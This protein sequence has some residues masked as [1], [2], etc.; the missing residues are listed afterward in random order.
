MET[1]REESNKLHQNTLD[2]LDEIV[3]EVH[4]I[5]E[6]Y[7]EKSS[8]CMFNDLKIPLQ[9]LQ[10]RANREFQII[11]ENDLIRV[12]DRLIELLKLL[13]DSFEKCNKLPNED[14]KIVEDY[15][16]QMFTFTQIYTEKIASRVHTVA[17][18]DPRA[19]KINNRI[20]A[21]NK[22]LGDTKFLI[23]RNVRELQACFKASKDLCYKYLTRLVDQA[24]NFNFVVNPGLV[25]AKMGK[26]KEQFALLYGEQ[27]EIE[28]KIEMNTDQD[29]LLAERLQ[30][31]GWM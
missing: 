11:D 17:G 12:M 24:V 14:Y 9:D 16:A 26:I 28:L 5:K 19:E 21:A 25:Q 15:E 29:R 4:L 8:S 23:L 31:E 27:L 20:N 18:L 1:R 13:R 7:K 10:R 3:N 22:L 6:D 2:R 30:R